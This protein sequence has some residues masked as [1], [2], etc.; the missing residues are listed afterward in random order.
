MICLWFENNINTG[1]SVP[2]MYCQKIVIKEKKNSS[3]Y[4]HSKKKR[5]KC[6]YPLPFHFIIYIIQYIRIYD[7]NVK[8]DGP[9]PPKEQLTNPG[10]TL[11][12]VAFNA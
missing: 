6:Y 3:R 2:M 7:E 4:F 1:L 12:S 8:W 5:A 10:T 11:S 9:K